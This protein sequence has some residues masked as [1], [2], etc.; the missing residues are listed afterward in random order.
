[1]GLIQL[2]CY[3]FAIFLWLSNPAHAQEEMCQNHYEWLSLKT[4]YDRD[5]PPSKNLS[6]E[7]HHTLTDINEVKANS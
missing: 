1:M 5:E 3:V 2:Y 7:I 6:I 4:H